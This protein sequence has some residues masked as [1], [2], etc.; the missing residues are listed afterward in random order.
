MQILTVNQWTEPGD[1]NGT[2]SGRAEGAEGD[3]NSIGRKTLSINLTP[4]SS[5]GLNHQQKSIHGPVYDSCY[6]CTGG[7]PQWTSKGEEVHGPV[8]A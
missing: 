6:I 1:P 8:E 5:Q 7:L 2:V 4:Q 3:C